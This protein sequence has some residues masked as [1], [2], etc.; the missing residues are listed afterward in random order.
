MATYPQLTLSYPPK[1]TSMSVIESTSG[2]AVVDGNGRL[3]ADGFRS[4]AA[5]WRWID[6]Q[7]GEPISRAESVAEWVWQKMADQP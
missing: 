1:G 2:W 7:E 4:N 3:L 5:A 6:R